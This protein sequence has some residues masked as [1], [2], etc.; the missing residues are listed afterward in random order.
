MSFGH[1][2]LDVYQRAIGSV[3][4]VWTFCENSQSSFGPQ[5]FTARLGGPLPAR[6]RAPPGLAVMIRRVG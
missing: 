3:G 6:G 4:W 2:K 5:K 1:E